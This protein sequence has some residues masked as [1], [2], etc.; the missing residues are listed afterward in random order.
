MRVIDFFELEDTQESLDFVNIN[1]ERDTLLFIE[2]FRVKYSKIL[3]NAEAV[4][5]KIQNFIEDVFKLFSNGEENKA[6]DLLLFSME[7]N[8]LRLGYSVSKNRGKGVSK[9]TLSEVFKVM[10]N[11]SHIAGKIMS[12]VSSLVL[13]VPSF[14]QDRMSDLIASIIKKE[15][16]EFTMKQAEM[17][18]LEIDKTEYNYGFYWNDET[19][20][21]DELI[22]Y[23]IRDS[24]GNAILFTPKDTVVTKYD[25][26]ATELM[27]KVIFPVLKEQ[28]TINNSTLV[29]RKV[30]KDGQI[31]LI[32]PNKTILYKHEVRDKFSKDIV[33]S[34]ILVQV[35]DAPEY[36]FEYVDRIGSERRLKKLSDD[37]LDS[38][39]K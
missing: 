22:G 34:F 23:S 15:L 24:D 26:S 17:L 6:L 21:W 9:E 25:Y 33:K 30:L 5:Y 13:F 19:S 28:H 1:V 11:N 31:K 16:Y 4:Y 32:G 3:P 29:E 36:Y 39:V 35:L 12:N 20:A 8:E 27:T 14:S 18:G 7:T 10:C 2:P 38:I 37:D